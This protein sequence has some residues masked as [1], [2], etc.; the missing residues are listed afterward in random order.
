MK[1]NYGKLAIFIAVAILT[2][3]MASTGFA[4]D[5]VANLKAYYRNIKVFKNG[6][7]VQFSSEP[8]IVDGTTYVPLR[9]ISQMLDKDVTWDGTSYNIGIND[10]PGFNPNELYNQVISQ[11][12]TI[13][14]L[15]AKIK[16]LEAGSGNTSNIT[17][18]KEMEKYLNKEYGIYK[19]IYFDIDLSETKSKI[20]VEIFVDL[21]EDYSRWN[22]LTSKEI[23][24]YLQD[25]V[26]DI[27]DAFPDQTISGYIED[28]A[29]DEELLSFTV[30][31]KG[32]VSTSKYSSSS[33]SSDIDDMEY[34]LDK[35]YAGKNG[36]E[37]V[38]LYKSGSKLY[39]TLYVDKSDWNYL[40]Y[41]KQD[42][43]LED[44]YDD[45]RYYFDETIDGE[46]VDDYNDKLL[47]EFDYSSKGVVTVY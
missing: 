14:Q 6:A 11:Q 43:I 13:T 5:T 31:S 42:G 18:I 33:S 46:I 24:S 26:D 1:K 32:K 7:Q 12:Q 35:A 28:S 17:S 34:D 20:K 44:M 47:Y 39:L 21:D 19:K 9:D 36:I 8:F 38:E 27:S 4:A 29:D 10:R 22:D 25:I 15:E 40:S 37:S 41:S 30:S 23:E 16:T 3:S 45:I 2:L